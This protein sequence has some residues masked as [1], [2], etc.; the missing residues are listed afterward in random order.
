MYHAPRSSHIFVELSLPAPPH[1]VWIFALVLLACR[2]GE[3]PES[4]AA[5]LTTALEQIAVETSSEAAPVEVSAVVAVTPVR[6]APELDPSAANVLLDVAALRTWADALPSNTESADRVASL[7]EE[8]ISSQAKRVLAVGGRPEVT[9]DPL[10]TMVAFSIAA[11]GLVVI[12]DAPLAAPEGRHSRTPEGDFR[13]AFGA[14]RALGAAVPVELPR[15][16]FFTFWAPSPSAVPAPVG[17]SVDFLEPAGVRQLGLGVRGDGSI[18]VRL[19]GE[20][21]RA[22]SL[23]LGRGQAFASQAVGQFNQTA[24]PEFQPWVTY[25][26]RVI[27]S[28]FAQIALAADETGTTLRVEAPMC[29]GAFRNLLSLAILTTLADAASEDTYTTPREFVAMTGHIGATCDVEIQGTPAG[30]PAELL[31]VGGTDASLRSAVI[32][33]DFGTVMRRGLPRGFGLLPFAL[34]PSM[35]ESV[36]GGRPFGM[37]GLDDPTS[38][39]VFSTERTAGSGAP[40]HRVI[41]FPPGM[42]SF[43]PPDS[44]I[45]TMRPVPMAPHV[46]FASPSVDLRERLEGEIASHWSEAHEAL[47]DGAYVAAFLGAGMVQPW[48]DRLERD[49]PA[50]SWVSEASGGLVWLDEE[51]AGA[52]LYGVSEPPDADAVR[53]AVPEL[54]GQISRGDNS[55]VS[56]REDAVRLALEQISIQTRPGTIELRLDGSTTAVV[57]AVLRIGLPMIGGESGRSVGLPQAF[58]LPR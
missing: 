53:A 44:G 57:A 13:L 16:A 36:F 23:A 37:D 56:E 45:D 24:P 18:L 25:A 31:R 1:I 26:N 17:S 21:P 28:L 12:S 29:G 4:P 50:R 6:L 39:F 52:M 47:P 46:A 15:D 41:L 5:D 9:V 8:A 7:V 40:A 43:L 48:A 54:L 30:I 51:G 2:G 20:D 3:A 14:E 10:A 58:Q 34:E 38:H 55:R 33:M 49:D 32:V 27:Q 42:R 35:L 22:V 11:D 19:E